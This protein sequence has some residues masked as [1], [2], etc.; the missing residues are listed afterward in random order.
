MSEHKLRVS[1]KGIFKNDKD[2]VLL[3]RLGRH[4]QEFWSAPGGGVEE[5]E[6]MI[7]TLNRELKEETGY[8]V[9]IGNLIFVQDI[10]FASG[11]RQLELFFQGKV[12][13]KISDGEEESKFFSRDEFKNIEF[14]PKNIDPFTEHSSIP[15]SSEV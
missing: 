2:E 7:E 15:F 10:K 6:P 5:D 8:K 12:L 13:E 4:G 11:A 3:V 9:K 14:L 1:I